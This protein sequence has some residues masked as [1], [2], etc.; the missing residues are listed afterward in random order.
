MRDS[1]TNLLDEVPFYYEQ[2]WQLLESNWNTISGFLSIYVF[3]LSVTLFLAFSNWKFLNHEI[4]H[5]KKNCTH[6]IPTRKKFGS[7][8]YPLEKKFGRTKYPRGHDETRPTGPTIAL[9][10][11]NLPN[12]PWIKS[13]LSTVWKV[14]VFGVILVHI[15]P[16]SDWIRTRITPNA[17]TFYS[18]IIFIYETFFCTD[19]LYKYWNFLAK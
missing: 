2:N 1:I 8:K 9:D 15:F 3:L 5:V 17:D 7:I 16:H 11:R 6:K 18:V 14:S 10:P 4:S 13:H 12:S 19:S